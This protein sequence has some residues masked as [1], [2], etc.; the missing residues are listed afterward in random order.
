MIPCA[1]D[2][3]YVTDV[4]H[5]IFFDPCNIEHEHTQ[6]N[7]NGSQTGFIEGAWRSTTVHEST[8]PARNIDAMLDLQGLYTQIIWLILRNE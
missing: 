1:T 5:N 3:A 2:V 4:A 8:S 6:I 7:M